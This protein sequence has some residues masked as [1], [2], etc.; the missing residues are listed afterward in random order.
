MVVIWLHCTLT[1]HIL[2]YKI[3]T[4][5]NGQRKNKEKNEIT[6]FYS[7]LHST[8]TIVSRLL[9]AYNGSTF[10]PAKAVAS[11]TTHLLLEIYL[12]I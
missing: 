10:F 9:H 3:V 8:T 4:L 11:S 2:L 6:K 5:T 7:N 12:G 1:L